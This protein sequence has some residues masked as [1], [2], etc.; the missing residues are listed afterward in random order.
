MRVKT[1]WWMNLNRN[2]GM[3]VPPWSGDD[4]DKK[5]KADTRSPRY[6]SPHGVEPRISQHKAGARSGI[7][8]PASSDPRLKANMTEI[9]MCQCLRPLV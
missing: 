6:L 7:A 8:V 4:H 5:G 9:R 3:V 1:D 2:R